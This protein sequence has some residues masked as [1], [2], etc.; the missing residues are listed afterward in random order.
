MEEK[1][2]P[3]DVTALL[4]ENFAQVDHW[5]GDEDAFL[6][7]EV[8]D[9][10]PLAPQ[11]FWESET[12]R[13]FP[14]G[15]ALPPA[16]ERVFFVDGKM[17]IHARILFRTAVLVLAEVAASWVLWERGRGLSFG[18]S[19]SSLPRHKRVLGAGEELAL[20]VAV[21]R[22]E[23]DLGMGMTFHLVETR[24][25]ARHFSDTEVAR[26]AV[27]NVM[28]RLE[29]EVVRDLLSESV[30][31]V[32]DGTIHFIDPPC[33]IPGVG[34]C[35]LVKRIAEL[36][37]P[38]DWLEKLLQ[39]PQ[40]R[41]TPF[42]AGF[43]GEDRTDVLRIFSYLRLLEDPAF[44]WKGLVRL[45]VVVPAVEFSALRLEISRFFDGLAQ[46]LPGLTGDYPW[47]RLPENLFPIIALEERLSQ[48]FAPSHLV[49]ELLRQ[50][51]WRGR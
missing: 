47:K 50:A 34:P 29:Q 22:Q 14:D 16:F 21:E 7:Q 51:L 26:Q 8:S 33:F 18:F 9:T 45:E 49:Q 3:R 40:G 1:R 44:P 27:L 12:W 37:F 41:R 19:P 11:E 2:E 43:L 28:Q 36:R 31:V 15:T 24:R 42:V 5:H 13:E 10:F 17:R 39:L 48:H 20:G 6:H 38:R 46:V 25:H 32:K 35:G 4:R 23:M 30:P